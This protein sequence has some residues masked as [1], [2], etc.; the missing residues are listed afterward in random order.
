[1]E[2]SDKNGGKKKTVIKTTKYGMQR[3]YTTFELGHTMVPRGVRAQGH[4]GGTNQRE[5]TLRLLLRRNTPHAQGFTTK[6]ALAGGPQGR[7]FQDREFRPSKK[8]RREE[9]KTK[10]NAAAISTP[11]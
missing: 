8:E 2:K 10:M 1:M 3:I 11:P 5:K 4:A 7:K 9:R 6:P